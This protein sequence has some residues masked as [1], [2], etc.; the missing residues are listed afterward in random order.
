LT[1][2]EF[3]RAITPREPGDLPQPAIDRRVDLALEARG[4]GRDA[5]AIE[6]L[7]AALDLLAPYP[8]GEAELR[9][10]LHVELAELLVAADDAE[11]ARVVLPSVDPGS[12][13]A[14]LVLRMLAV[15]LRLA[16]PGGVKNAL[17]QVAARLEALPASLVVSE[18]LLLAA[19]RAAERIVAGD[20][21]TAHSLQADALRGWRQLPSNMALY[22]EPGPQVRRQLLSNEVALAAA[23]GARVAERIA[24]A[25]WLQQLGNDTPDPKLARI[26]EQIRPE[27]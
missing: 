24:V 3:V 15:Q 21:D 9:L 11:A 16:Q 18:R 12:D 19:V 10:R 13:A 20:F 23:P 27:R 7:R 4:S 26:K 17:A 2:E 8:A 22:L 25:D 6:H 5:A 14:D 1:D